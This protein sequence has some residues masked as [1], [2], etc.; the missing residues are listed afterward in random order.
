MDRN[1]YAIRMASWA[2]II[3][4]ANNSGLTKSR[5]CREHG[6]RLRQFH[7]WQKRIRE[8]L[9][10]HPDTDFE[11]FAGNGQH[12]PATV[13]EQSFCEISIPRESSAI[14]AMQPSKISSSHP[15]LTFRSITYR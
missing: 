14:P 3:A 4:E 1:S 15:A 8:F 13:S 6:I 11:D 12:L 5:W 7:Y 9:L 2:K 10:E